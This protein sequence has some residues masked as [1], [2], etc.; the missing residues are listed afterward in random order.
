MTFSFCGEK[1]TYLRTVTNVYNQWAPVHAILSWQLKDEKETSSE[2][3]HAY[4]VICSIL[5]FINILNMCITITCSLFHTQ[6]STNTCIYTS[7]PSSFST[8]LFLPIP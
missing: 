4:S 8:G 2:N 7:F 5:T 3:Q 6:T 1:S